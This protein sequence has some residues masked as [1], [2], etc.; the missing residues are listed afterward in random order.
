MGYFWLIYDRSGRNPY[1]NKERVYHYR[2]TVGGSAKLSEGDLV[3]LYDS[4]KYSQV[5][6]GAGQVT[7]IEGYLRFEGP[8][9]LRPVEDIPQGGEALMEYLSQ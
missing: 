3:V 9:S 6:F 8:D 2:S 5:I 4:Y 1:S 7:K